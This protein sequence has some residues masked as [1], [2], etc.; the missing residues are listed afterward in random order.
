MNPGNYFEF[1]IACNEIVPVIPKYLQYGKN[2]TTNMDPLFWQGLYKL[3]YLRQPSWQ[4][5]AKFLCEKG[6]H[7]AIGPYAEVRKNVYIGMHEAVHL[8]IDIVVQPSTPVYTPL[9]GIVRE[10]I[11]N[12]SLGDYGTL[13]VVE[14][15]VMSNKFFTIYG[16]LSAESCF[17]LKQFQVIAAGGFIGRVGDEQQNGGWPPHLHFQISS[18]YLIN[19]SIFLGA[20]EKSIANEYLKYCPDPNLLLKMEIN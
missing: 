18:E 9:P 5:I 20:V 3:A 10:I 4:Q 14:H 15:E 19:N 7:I 2:I 13:V 8:G 1:L 17:Y 11:V 16:H 12:N 6:V